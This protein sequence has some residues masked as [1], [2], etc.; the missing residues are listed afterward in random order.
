MDVNP[1]LSALRRFLDKEFLMTLLREIN[2]RSISLAANLKARQK[3]FEKAEAAY[4]QWYKNHP[5]GGLLSFLRDADPSLFVF[6]FPRLP[7]GPHDLKVFSSLE[8]A[9]VDYEECVDSLKR[10]K[11]KPIPQGLAAIET[12]LRRQRIPALGKVAAWDT[13]RQIAARREQPIKDALAEALGPDF[14]PP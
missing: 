2:P 8:L 13:R 9:A 6:S 4:H 14:D 12:H 11:L 10:K 3:W 5:G 1:D 7:R